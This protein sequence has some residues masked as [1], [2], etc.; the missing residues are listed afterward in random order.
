[1]MAF[2]YRIESGAPSIEPMA[3]KAKK[4]ESFLHKGKLPSPAPLRTAN[5][6]A[7]TRRCR[8]VINIQAIGSS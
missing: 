5:I 2:G 1:M 4:S 6:K 8:K 3:R 7:Q